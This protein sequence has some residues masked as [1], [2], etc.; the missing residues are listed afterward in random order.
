MK[1]LLTTHFYRMRTFCNLL[2]QEYLDKT[3]IYSRAQELYI[4]DQKCEAY[5]AIEK[6]AALIFH[7]WEEYDSQDENDDEINEALLKMH[8]NS[9]SYVPMDSIITSSMC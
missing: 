8:S 6:S 4:L 9:S 1:K 2:N 5:Q 7:K 3:N